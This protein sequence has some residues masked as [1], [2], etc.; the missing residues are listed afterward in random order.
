MPEK[1]GA[2]RR[3]EEA[4]AYE[5]NDCA[6][7]SQEADHSEVFEEQRFPKRVSCWENDGRQDNSKENLIVKYYLVVHAV[8]D[9]KSCEESHDDGDTWF[10]QE[11]NLVRGEGT[12]WTSIK[13][14]VRT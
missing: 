9:K 2:Y 5:A 6:D 8:F 12:L 3:A 10:M 13:W 1:K 14:A 7:Y 4:E 11:R